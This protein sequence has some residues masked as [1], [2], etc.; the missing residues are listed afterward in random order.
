MMLDSLRPVEAISVL[1]C[2][3]AVGHDTAYFGFT[4]SG[5]TTNPAR[6][7]ARNLQ[8]AF[9]YDKGPIVLFIFYPYIKTEDG[10]VVYEV[11]FRGWLQT[12]AG[13][14][15]GLVNVN[16]VERHVQKAFETGDSVRL[17]LV[18]GEEMNQNGNKVSKVLLRKP[19]LNP[20]HVHSYSDRD[21]TAR[22]VRSQS[23]VG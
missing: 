13:K 1:K 18:S 6:N 8:W 5:E 19:D 12:F 17:V 14:P 11:D 20:W 2:L 3:Q 16:L 23:P 7:T 15:K 9:G 22:L 21:R 4:K 10:Q